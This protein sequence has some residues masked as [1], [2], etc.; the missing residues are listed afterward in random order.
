MRNF[1]VKGENNKE[2]GFLFQI[3]FNE[4]DSK[5]S[6][7]IDTCQLSSNSGTKQHP[8]IWASNPPGR[9]DG[10]SAGTVCF[11]RQPSANNLEDLCT[12]GLLSPTKM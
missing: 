12:V 10:N 9:E 5:F 11:S 2:S 1:P 6:I 8:S 7:V 4:D 3:N